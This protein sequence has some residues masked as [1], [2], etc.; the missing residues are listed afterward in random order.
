MQSVRIGLVVAAVVA[1]LLAARAY[2]PTEERRVRSRLDDLARSVGER[3]GQGLEQ[4]ARA[5]RLAGYFTEDVVV[6]LGEPYPEFRGR[7]TIMALAAKARGH[8]DDFA[9][10]FEDVAVRLDEDGRGAGVRLVVVLTG[11]SSRW[12]AD[13]A[14]ARELQVRMQR[15]DGAWRIAQVTNVEAIARPR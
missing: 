11:R 1:A 4:M 6:D 15:D 2:W 10:R 5:A 9:V 3:D 13:A 12:V 7:D 8:D 14:D